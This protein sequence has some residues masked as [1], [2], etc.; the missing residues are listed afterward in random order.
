MKLWILFLFSV[1]ITLHYWIAYLR[2]EGECEQR[3]MNFT[4]EMLKGHPLYVNPVIKEE[5]N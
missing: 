3:K 2:L 4:L 1:I 5:D